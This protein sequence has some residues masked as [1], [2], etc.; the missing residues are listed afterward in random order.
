MV[1]L[2]PPVLTNSSETI[3]NLLIIEILLY[4]V[5]LTFDLASSTLATRL[6]CNEV[7]KGNVLTILFCLKTSFIRSTDCGDIPAEAWNYKVQ[8]KFFSLDLI[9]M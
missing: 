2:A 4:F 7:I 1:A 8:N 9:S 6:C 3:I 5:M